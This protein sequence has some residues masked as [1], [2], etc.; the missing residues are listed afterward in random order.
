MLFETILIIN[1]IPQHLSWHQARLDRSYRMEFG[2]ENRAL[3][4][5]RIIQM[6][7]QF[8]GKRVRCRFTYNAEVWNAEYSLQVPRV[9]KT[10]KLV[11]DDTI[12]YACKYTDRD[13]LNALFGKRGEADDILIIRKGLVTDTSIANIL[14]LSGNTWYTPQE[15]LL[16]GTTV[17][18][19]LHEGRVQKAVIRET[20]LKKYSAFLTVNALNDFDP[21]RLSSSEYIVS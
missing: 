13:R 16:Q 11:H 10:L 20:D 15:P 1:S 18:R 19:L 21:S 8:A 17:A 7:E 12:G 4:L 6:P 3:Q 9:I 2:I 5:D 14:L